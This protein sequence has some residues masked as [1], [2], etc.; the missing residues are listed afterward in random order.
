MK[1]INIQIEN[2]INQFCKESILSSTK[3]IKELRKLQKSLK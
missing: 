2:L 3:V 1:E